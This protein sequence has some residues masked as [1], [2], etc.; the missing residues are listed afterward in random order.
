VQDPSQ[1]WGR[2]VGL[3]AVLIVA[4]LAAAAAALR[5]G[6]RLPLRVNQIELPSAA[7]TEPH[8]DY[9]PVTAASDR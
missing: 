8:G 5:L 9:L 6:Q 7:D 4:C 1:S 3:F 2:R